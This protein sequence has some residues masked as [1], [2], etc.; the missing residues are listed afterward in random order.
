M[1]G[2]MNLSRKFEKRGKFSATI[3]S[4]VFKKIIAGKLSNFLESNSL[5]PLSQFS[6]RRALGTCNALLTLSHPLQVAL[7]RVWREGLFS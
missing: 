2:L 6:Y 7:D 1:S 4:N 3:F 5:P